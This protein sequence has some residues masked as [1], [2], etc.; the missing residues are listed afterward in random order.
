MSDWSRVRLHVVTGK[1]GTGKSTVAASLAL[2]LASQGKD[3]LLCEVEGRQG[4]AQMYDV[5]PLPYA[6]RRIARGLRTDGPEEVVP[7]YITPRRRSWSTSG[8]I[9]GSAG[10]PGPGP[11]RGR[12]VRDHHRP[13]RPRRAAHREGLRGGA[14]QQPQQGGD[15][16][17]R[18][19][20]RRAADRPD[21]AVPQRR[22]RAGRTGQGGADQEAGRHDD[23][24]VPLPG[25]PCTSSPYSRRCR[26]RRPPTGSCTSARRGSPSAAWW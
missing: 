14:A 7:R 16:V 8:C 19:R 4:V 18:R 17:R 25:Q 9:T 24:A 26:S 23:D 20:A 21:H 22:R 11:V 2:A 10:R 12:R 1:G 13:G 5:D 15:R 3:V 6:E